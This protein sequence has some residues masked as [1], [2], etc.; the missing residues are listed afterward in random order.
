MTDYKL[1]SFEIQLNI[2]SF[3]KNIFLILFEV[4]DFLSVLKKIIHPMPSEN[5]YVNKDYIILT[6][7]L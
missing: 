2:L 6:Y 1:N 4:F 5:T 3:F 7:N